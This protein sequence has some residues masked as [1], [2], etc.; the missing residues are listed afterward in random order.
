MGLE[1]TVIALNAAVVRSVPV[2]FAAIA[3]CAPTAHAPPAAPTVHAPPAAPT[4][5]APPAAPTAHA[6]PAAPT[7]SSTFD[8]VLKAALAQAGYVGG[9]GAVGACGRVIWSGAAGWAKLRPRTAM[10]AE[11]ASRIGSVSKVLTAAAFL[12]MSERNEVSLDRPVGVVLPTLPAQLRAVLPRQILN[13]TSGIRHYQ[14]DEFLSDRRYASAIAALSI[15]SNDPLLFAP[16][17][18]YAYSTYAFT[19]LAAVMESA[20][21]MAF[22]ALIRRE[23]LEPAKMTAT[24]AEDSNETASAPRADYHDGQDGR[25][26]IAPFVDN[27]YKWAGG[28]YVATAPDLVRFGQALLDGRLVRADTWARMQAPQ[29]GDP[30]VPARFGIGLAIHWLERMK[31]ARPEPYDAAFFEQLEGALRGAR[32][33]GHSGGS[34]GAAAFLLIVP[35][36]Q[37]VVGALSNSP[38]APYFV[39]ELVLEALRR[40]PRCASAK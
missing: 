9:A 34:V 28:G 4:V 8:R 11:T 39:F 40:V 26:T 31:A 13:H 6:P 27:S 7:P 38:K 33:V 30:Q 32:I 12:R 17:S 20:T 24:W 19:L 16:G 37:I 25:V 5:H 36:R 22:P 29:N 3:A 18:D 21:S 14:G 35:E 2:V 23:I 1:A 15:F 10:T